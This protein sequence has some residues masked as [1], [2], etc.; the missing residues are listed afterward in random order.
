MT[1][2]E[3]SVLDLKALDYLGS[4]SSETGDHVIINFY[5]GEP[6]GTAIH[7]VYVY[8]LSGQIADAD[9]NCR[10]YFPPIVRI[11]EGMLSESV[12]NARRWLKIHFEQGAISFF[13]D[14]AVSV[15]RTVA[16]ERM[17]VRG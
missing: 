17:H 4:I 15:K 6:D 10:P 5:S 3:I 14:Q 2:E 16:L 12:G 7:N 13:Y 9:I 1:Q 11:E 8:L